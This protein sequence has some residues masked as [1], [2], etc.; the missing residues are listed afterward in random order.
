MHPTVVDS[1]ENGCIEQTHVAR[2]PDRENIQCRNPM[3]SY[4]ATVDY[5]GEA[6]FVVLG[7]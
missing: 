7:V 6:W 4:P 2:G 5:R 1:D 3:S